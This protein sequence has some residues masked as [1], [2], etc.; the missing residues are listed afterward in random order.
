MELC[1]ADTLESL[2][3]TRPKPSKSPTILEAV[4]HPSFGRYARKCSRALLCAAALFAAGCHHN[5]YDSGYG[6]GW[7]TL[8]GT[9]GDFT[10]Y[11]VNVN[12]V[13]LT[14]KA[15]GVITAVYAAEIVDFT[16]LNDISELWSAASIPNDTYSAATIV[17]DYTNAN[18][19][20]MVNGVPTKANV[21]D[22]TGKPV[23]TQTVNITF[24]SAYQPVIQPT[25][26]SRSA[27]RLA[28]N[29]DISASNVVNMATS[30]PTV[31]IKP[32][33]TVATSAP[34]TKPV[35]V[36]GPLINSSIGVGTYT[37]YVRPFYDEANNLGTLSIFN[38]PNATVY[39]LDGTTYTGSKGLTALSKTSAGS[40]ETAA[41]TTYQPAPTLNASVT[42][43]KFNSIYVSAGSTLEDY[44]TWGLEGDVIARSGNTLT[45]RGATLQFNNGVIPYISY[46]GDVVNTP[47]AVV[48][49]GPATIVTA[50]DNPTLTHLDYN[51][52]SVGQ[53]I[54][55]RGVYTLPASGVTT[56]DA[57]GTVTNKGSVR[58]V[59]TPLWGSLVSSAAGSLVLNLQAIENWP[60]SIYDFSGNGAAA[61][62]PASYVVNTG[63]L[64]I[65][66]GA[67]AGVPLW[68]GG[69]VTP[70]GSAP[71]DFNAVAVNAELSV[72]ARLQV[73]WTSAGTTAPF[74]T[75]TSAGLTIDLA[76]ANY[77]SG[78]IRI[79]SESI[80]LKSLAASPQIVPAAPIGDSG[81]PAKFMPS[82]A[83]GNLTSTANTTAIAVFNTFS[84][85]VTQ[86]P[87]SL[88]AA[89]PALHFVAAGV[90]NRGTNIF[91]AS[92]IDVVN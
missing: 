33:M 62:T 8:S 11:V 19:S 91:T 34:D 79:G 23:T 76:N 24:D 28:L 9:P 75:L 29:F 87:L 21:V 44:Y 22:T 6:I 90:Y 78:V 77:S 74:A 80:D 47:D 67:A 48:L 36:R 82:F 72:P 38:D 68:I 17:L 35:R 45:V 13:A 14:G 46:V 51:S 50:D 42:A 1:C 20:V 65:P 86:A 56:L 30:P 10:S 5:S 16:K 83:I 32:F 84:G 69:T 54:I 18:I 49:L 89:T 66:A 4:V 70:F 58:L 73:D 43:G 39:T 3:S 7:V 55:A 25:Y 71:P 27:I 85:F 12:S 57:T 81:L 31:T 41:Y 40:T 52:V 15:N 59:S 26:A 61:V 2:Y 64:A 63:S 53:H 37:V 60:V 92:S 88:V